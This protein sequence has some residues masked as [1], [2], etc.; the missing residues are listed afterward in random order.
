[1]IVGEEA[2]DDGDVSIPTK[3]TIG[4]F[5]QDV[6]EMSGRSVLDEAIAGSGRVGD[7]HHELEALQHAMA[8]PARAGDMDTHPRAVRPGPGG[9]RAPRRLRAREP[10]AR[11]PARPRVRRRAD[12]RRRRRAVGRMEDAGGDGARAARPARRAADGR[13]DQPS[14]HRIDHLAR[15]VPEVAARRAADDVARH[16]TS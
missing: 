5:R 7:L 6:E 1:M 2:P 10:G 9:V 3:L 12:R 15:G 16:A 14:R 8:D 11:G 13:A 4:Y